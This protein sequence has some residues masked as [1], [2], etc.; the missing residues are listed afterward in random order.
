MIF[1]VALLVLVAAVVLAVAGVATNSG[2]GHSSGDRFVIFGHHLDAVSTG[3]LFLY[4]IVVGAV[5]MLALSMLLGAFGRRSASRR[6]RRE[7][8]GSRSET[9]DA[10]LDRDRLTQQLDDEHAELRRLDDPRVSAASN[11]ESI[12]ETAPARP[13]SENI[14]FDQPSTPDQ[15]PAERSGIRQRISRRP[16]R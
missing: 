4:G 13:S 9:T 16:G 6:A 7:L 12:D 11:G 8:R 1:I 10:R 3:Q 15:I 5:G 14:P 2:S